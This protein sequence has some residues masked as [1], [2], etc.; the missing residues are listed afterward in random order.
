V[1]EAKFFPLRMDFSG[2]NQIQ[3]KT[4]DQHKK[5][6]IFPW[7]TFAYRKMSFSLKK[8]GATFEHAMTFSFHDIKHI[9]KD[10][11]DDLVSHSCKREDHVTHLRIIF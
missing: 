9:V 5:D 7:G 10:Y 3:I 1:R 2:Y 11:H 8:A 4:E 6:F